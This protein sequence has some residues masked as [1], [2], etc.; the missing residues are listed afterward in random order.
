MKKYMIDKNHFNGTKIPMENI[1]HEIG[2]ICNDTSENTSVLGNS[3]NNGNRISIFTNYA[4]A[5]RN[6]LTKNE[7]VHEGILVS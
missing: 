3:S 5:T 4:C 6:I 2:L 1:D 7:A